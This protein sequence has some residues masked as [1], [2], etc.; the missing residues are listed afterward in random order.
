MS[1]S[2]RRYKSDWS[3]RPHHTVPFGNGV[4]VIINERK[5]VVPDAQAARVLLH[6]EYLRLA[7][8]VWNS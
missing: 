7:E 2:V 8:A 4:L 1:D 3:R 6:T 5:T